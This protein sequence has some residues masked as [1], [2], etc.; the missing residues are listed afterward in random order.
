MQGA[1]GTARTSLCVFHQGARSIKTHVVEREYKVAREGLVAF[2]KSKSLVPE[3]HRSGFKIGR[4]LW[5][6]L[7]EKRHPSPHHFL[8]FRSIPFSLVLLSSLL[9]YVSQLVI[10]LPDYWGADVRSVSRVAFL[11]VFAWMPKWYKFDHVTPLSSHWWDF[12][13]HHSLWLFAL[14]LIRLSQL[15]PPH[16]LPTRPLPCLEVPTL[17][18]SFQPPEHATFSLSLCPC[19]INSFKTCLHRTWPCC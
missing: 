4:L 10:H 11:V 6:S 13:F 1:G 5:N 3:R 14:P 9:A 12:P 19:Y 7:E 18:N 17:L 2:C 8:F 16:L 15:D